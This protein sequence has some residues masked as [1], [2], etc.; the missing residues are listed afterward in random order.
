MK[1]KAILHATDEQ[2]YFGQ[3]TVYG[4]TDRV[5]KLMAQMHDAPY[6]VCLHRARCFTEVY[7]AN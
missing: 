3:T 6:G 4:C 2:K 1:N 7:Q 5:R